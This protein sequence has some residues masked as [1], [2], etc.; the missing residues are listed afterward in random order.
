[1]EMK[2]TREDDG[3]DAD[4]LRSSVESN[5]QKDQAETGLANTKSSSSG[6]TNDRFKGLSSLNNLLVSSMLPLSFLPSALII[7]FLSL[8]ST[9]ML[10]WPH[11]ACYRSH[12]NVASSSCLTIIH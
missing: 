11:V 1:M 7:P 8:S 5:V 2:Q 12:P 4:D 3:D 10:S 9:H 6:T